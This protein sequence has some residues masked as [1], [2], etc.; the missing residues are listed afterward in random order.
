MIDDCELEWQTAYEICRQR[1]RR[2]PD[3]RHV[4]QGSTL[5]Q[6]ARGLVSFRCGGNAIAGVEEREE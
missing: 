6:C 1:W 3:F 2:D 5:H 4:C